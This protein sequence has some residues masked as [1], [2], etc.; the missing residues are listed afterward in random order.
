MR[1]QPLELEFPASAPF[2]VSCAAGA[3]S[4]MGTLHAGTPSHVTGARGIHLPVFTRLQQPLG[5]LWGSPF[6]VLP[7]GVSHCGCLRLMFNSPI[8][9]SGGI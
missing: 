3:P 7:F 5:S 8:S 6:W 9:A 4:G 2:E 1:W